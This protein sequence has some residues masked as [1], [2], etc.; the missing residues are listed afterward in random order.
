[1][2]KHTNSEAVRPRDAATVILIRGNRKKPF[3]L[4][5]MQRH[6]NQ[7]FMGGAYVF[8]G[9]ALD[10]AD[11][12]PILSSYAKGLST[13]EAV[14]RLNEPDLSETKAL[15]LFFTAV[16]ETFEESGVLL[17]GLDAKTSTP[18]ADTHTTDCFPGYREKLHQGSVT[19]RD[20]AAK[21]NIR[22][23]LDMLLPY[24]RWITPELEKKRF[25]TRFFL[26]RMPKNQHPAHD[27]IELTDSLWVTPAEALKKQANKEILLMPPT[28]KIMEELSAYTSVD[29][30][31]SAASSR[32]VR[33]IL[34]Q[35]FPTETGF[36]VKLPHD[37]EYN[38]TAYKQPSRDNDPSRIVM[39]DGKW[40]TMCVN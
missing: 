40:I 14:T 28:L 35:A 31:F 16:R 22:Y 26:A 7:R 20:F 9:G 21:K 12:D 2:D 34:P 3:E 23:A 39:V 5:L 25:D 29:H 37:P 24:A 6:K 11:C 32:K 38:I 19:L 1:M 15:G 18:G 10:S 13:K 33:P 8:P 27:A 4:F 36:G 17:A 30:L